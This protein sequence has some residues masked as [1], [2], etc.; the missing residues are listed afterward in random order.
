M[1]LHA[2]AYVSFKIV[3][4]KKMENLLFGDMSFQLNQPV[5]YL[6][7]DYELYPSV[8]IPGVV[9][10]FNGKLHTFY[11]LKYQTVLEGIKIGYGDYKLP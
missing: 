9:G 4:A 11:T 7:T 5:E 10:F 2:K 1:F 6:Q 8:Y 3:S